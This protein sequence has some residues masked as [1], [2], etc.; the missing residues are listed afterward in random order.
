M[1]KTMHITETL[2]DIRFIHNNNMNIII[3]GA[4][5]GIGSEIAKLFAN[6]TNNHIILISRNQE[7]LNELIND[8]KSN[9]ASANISA[10]PFDLTDINEIRELIPKIKSSFNK[11]DILINNAGFLVNK[12]FDKITAAEFEQ[13]YKV[14]VLGPA[15]LIRCLI[16]ELKK[17]DNAHVVNISSMGGF[18][19]SMKFP[20][21]TA[22]AS[23]KAA[24]A[25]L[26]EC[27]AEEYKDSNIKFNCLALGAV[28]TEML[29]EA[30]PGYDA[31]TTAKEMAEYITDF[32]LKG[33]K[34]YNGKILPVSKTTP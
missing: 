22:Y 33:H 16:P 24:I 25:N 4:S 15:E 34:M 32:A 6:N 20:G 17:S 23:S 19:G 10:L 3:T 30:F 26:T 8:C 7:K 11:L 29:A 13:I 14:N 2:A 28:A 12:P 21:L 1:L 9:N 18:Q 27:L 31:P 5:R